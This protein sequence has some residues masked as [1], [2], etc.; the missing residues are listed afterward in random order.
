[1]SGRKCEYSGSFCHA[2]DILEQ[3]APS[4][5]EEFRK[6]YCLGD[7]KSCV[8]YKAIMQKWESKLEEEIR[9]AEHKLVEATGKYLALQLL[10]TLKD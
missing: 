4:S 2:E 8:Q 9:K 6:T 7:N 10:K 1:M 5:L 3:Y